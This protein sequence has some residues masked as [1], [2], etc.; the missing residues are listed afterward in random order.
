MRVTYAAMEHQL[1][2]ADFVLREYP[3]D[4]CPRK[5]MGATNERAAHSQTK[6]RTH[7]EGLHVVASVVGN[8]RERK[9]GL[10]AQWCG[11][12]RRK[13]SLGRRDV[14]WKSMLWVSVSIVGL[15]STNTCGDSSQL[16]LPAMPLALQWILRKYHYLN[17]PVN[18]MT[19]AVHRAKCIHV[20]WT[21][22]M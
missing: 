14:F 18:L 1:E 22:C 7:S 6:T 12:A 9:T 15:T 16:K 5:W 11:F 19:Q 20:A 3:R 13:C 8:H 21:G 4:L 2:T 10:Q 17:C